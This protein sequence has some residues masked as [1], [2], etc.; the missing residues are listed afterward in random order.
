MN[1]SE[2][3]CIQTH[4]SCE[5][6]HI[7]LLS[8]LNTMK[9]VFLQQSAFHNAHEK[10]RNRKSLQQYDIWQKLCHYRDRT[11]V[12]QCASIETCEILHFKLIFEH[13][14]RYAC[15]S[16]FRLCSW[17]LQMT[18]ADYADTDLYCH[19]HRELVLI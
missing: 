17:K 10:T 5:T 12:L 14:N 11:L 6:Q 8:S 19:S 7:R 15:F 18:I 9:N 13:N 16:Y 3:S 1:Q 2:K 4:P